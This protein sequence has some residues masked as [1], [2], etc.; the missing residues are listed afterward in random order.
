[1]STAKAILRV[2]APLMA[3]EHG[4]ASAPAVRVTP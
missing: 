4:R 2:R 1:M 3:I